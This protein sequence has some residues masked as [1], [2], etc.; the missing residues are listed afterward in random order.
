[1]PKEPSQRP[2]AGRFARDE[3]ELL[4]TLPGRV[5]V[6]ASTTASPTTDPTAAVTGGLAGLAAI[7]A[8]HDSASPLV[9]EVVAAIYAESL[10]AGV[11]AS[12]P[13]AASTLAAGAHAAELLAANADPADA[14]AYR[15]W[16]AGI[17]GAVCG[18]AAAPGTGRLRAAESRYWTLARETSCNFA[19]DLRAAL[20]RRVPRA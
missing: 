4:V 6:T 17:A 2:A 10:H 8:G 5:L 14:S 3:W 16:L 13:P 12:D 9:R 1:M 20:S 11:P 18:A 19:D 15:D 7:A